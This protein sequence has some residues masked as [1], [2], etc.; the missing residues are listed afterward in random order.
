MDGIG[1]LQP[2]WLPSCRQL[3]LLPKWMSA[4]LALRV[5]EG[6]RPWFGYGWEPGK[7]SDIQTLLDNAMA[8]IGESCKNGKPGK[9]TSDLV[10]KL[11][12]LQKH[13]EQHASRA[14]DIDLFLIRAIR[15]CTSAVQ[16]ES[17]KAFAKEAHDSIVNALYAAQDVC[18]KKAQQCRRVVDEDHFLAWRKVIE[19]EFRRRVGDDFRAMCG[20]ADRMSFGYGAPFDPGRITPGWGTLNVLPLESGPSQHATS[21]PST[22]AG[23]VPA[24][25]NC[26]STAI[27]GVLDAF[28]RSGND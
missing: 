16:E 25:L 7:K 3:E 11:S 15:Q 17:P 10:E 21:P 23:V 6:V 20:F 28:P 13:V 14:F 9:A 8:D 26:A 24:M 27:N 2:G 19:A 5:L 22:A 18:S 4:T 1:V 12:V